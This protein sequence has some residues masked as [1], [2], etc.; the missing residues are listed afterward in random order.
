MSVA[1]IKQ[2]L[3]ALKNPEKIEVYKWFFKT[4]KGDYGEGD[5]FLGLNQDQIKKIAKKYSDL[6]LKGVKALLSSKIHED[7]MTATRILVYKFIK[8]GEFEREKI[9]TFYLDNAKSV[10]NWDLVDVSAP[11]IVGGFLLKN[12]KGKKVL[13]RL[14]KSENLWEKRIS[15]I[16]TQQFIRAGQFDDTLK[17][18]K[19]LFSDKHDLIHKAVGWMLREV[20]KRD[21]RVERKFLAK[22]YKVM[23]RTALR[24]A[25]ER[26]GPKLRFK[27]LKHAR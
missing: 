1:K 2:E 9:Y 21:Q 14:A 4:G 8:S 7:R 23:P 5:E 11:T 19:I 13:Y 26:F 16:A 22:Y 12:Q 3:R 6:N 17:I 27:Y 15:I 18:A 24:Y 10:N 25:I 20:G